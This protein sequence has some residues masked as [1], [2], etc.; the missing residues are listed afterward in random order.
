MSGRSCL[1]W[2]VVVIVAIPLGWIVFNLVLGVFGI[3][4]RILA[5]AEPS[6]LLSPRI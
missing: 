4:V 3:G 6:V 2:A 5:D 1:L